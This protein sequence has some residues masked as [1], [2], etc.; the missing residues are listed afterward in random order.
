MKDAQ[1]YFE[2]TKSNP[3]RPLTMKF[4]KMNIK[5]QK[6]V[7]L[8][9]GAGNDTVYLIKN[10]WNVTA[11]D[12]EN[13]ENFILEKLDEDEIKRFKFSKQDFES[14]NLEENDLVLANYSIPFCNKNEF[15]TFWNKIVNSIKEDGYFV[16]NFFGTNDSWSKTKL[17]KTFLSKEEVLELFRNKFEIVLFEEIENDKMT[18]N[19]NMKHWHIFNVIAKKM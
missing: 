11:V 7:E 3:P 12:S 19:G 15:N 18:A 9:C 14:L 10:G 6:A 5:P 17:D 1:K 8:G 13:T 4:I 2:N 16:G